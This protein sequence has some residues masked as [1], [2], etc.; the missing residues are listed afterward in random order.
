M[1][2]PAVS[3][4]L[5]TLLREDSAGLAGDLGPAPWD[6]IVRE[7]MAQGLVPWLFRRLE[8]ADGL[9]WLPAETAD[10][11]R[12]GA[13][14]AG[15]RSLLLA[16]ELA[17]LLRACTE[18]GVR[19]APVRGPA[20]AERLY[21]DAAA[22]PTGDLDLVVPRSELPGL[23]ALLRD[24]GFRELSHHSRFAELFSYTLALVKDRH[25]WIVV[26]PHWTIAYPPYADRVDMD[27]VWR[28]A[29]RARVVGVETWSL[30]PEDL[31][32]HLCLHLM[33]PDGGVPLLW[34]YEVDRFV[35]QARREIDWS[36]FLS[37]VRT[38]GPGALAGRALGRVRE[39]FATPLPA[40]TVEALAAAPAPAERRVLQLLADGAYVDGRE[41]LATL[42]SLPTARL[43][44][45][46]VLGLL[47][48][49]PEF[50]MIQNG[51]ALRR[52]LPLAYLRR[53]GRLAWRGA[54]ATA[55]LVR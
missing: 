21:G 55:R 14:G 39:L 11:L 2:A 35:R 12:Q 45:R 32:F 9:R 18:R 31:L 4:E 42:L 53:C 43:R 48:P 29:A 26:E 27:A 10:V 24:L 52:D 38:P 49:S 46:Y 22:R 28:R 51:L 19:C 23:V 33:H 7:A 44:A 34:L 25:G 30:A 13:L 3:S 16:D 15:A 47:F 5:L 8:R 17:R 54:R 36:R 6:R 50:M 41:E 37:L 1:S 40:P 20:L